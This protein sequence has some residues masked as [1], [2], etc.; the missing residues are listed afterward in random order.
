MKSI[1]RSQT[2]QWLQTVVDFLETDLG[3]MRESRK[4]ELL[5]FLLYFTL[6]TFPAVFPVS[7]VDD[8]D[9]DSNFPLSKRRSQAMRRRGQLVEVALGKIQKGLRSVLEAFGDGP[10]QPNRTTG[11]AAFKLGET[12]CKLVLVDYFV[13]GE[14]WFDVKVIPKA[15]DDVVTL[16]KLH[17]AH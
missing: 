1:A 12:I 10:L 14:P 4:K 9:P 11:P 8:Q 2:K 13:T 17:L 7:S 3:S 5:D 15:Q 16:A 6:D